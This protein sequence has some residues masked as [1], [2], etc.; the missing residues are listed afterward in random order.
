MRC[1]GGY[2]AAV[3][4]DGINADRGA[5]DYKRGVIKISSGET[6]NICLAPGGG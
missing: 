2:R 4:E 6:L 3:F 5:T 1:T